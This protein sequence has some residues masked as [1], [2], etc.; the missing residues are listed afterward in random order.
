MKA[1]SLH[2]THTQTTPIIKQYALVLSILTIA[3][4]G[5]TYYRLYTLPTPVTLPPKAHAPATPLQSSALHNFVH[6]L[7]Y[8]PHGIVLTHLS[9]TQTALSLKGTLRTKNALTPFLKKIAPHYTIVQAKAIENG[10]FVLE[11]KTI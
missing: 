11:L 1:F 9:V 6:I 2:T 8:I 4:T 10:S 5:Y 3:L 7:E